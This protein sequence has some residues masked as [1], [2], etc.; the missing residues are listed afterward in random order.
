MKNKT[1]VVIIMFFLSVI[2]LYNGYCNFELPVTVKVMN[3]DDETV[4][5]ARVQAGFDTSDIV[6]KKGVQ[7]V[8]TTDREGMVSFSCYTSGHIG[9][10]V[11]KNA[12][13][14]SWVSMNFFKNP[15]EDFIRPYN[16][17]EKPIVITMRKRINPIPMHAKKV[18]T[19][20]PKSDVE[21][22]YDLMVGDWVT[23]LGKGETK[24][25]IFKT[26]GYW[27]GRYDNYSELT[28]TFSNESDG[29]I[30]FE[31]DPMY[32]SRLRSSN[33]APSEGYKNQRVWIQMR[34]PADEGKTGNDLVRRDYDKR[35]NYYL[36]V[37]SKTDK[38]GR[39][40]SA[41][42]GKIYGDIKYGGASEDGCFLIFKY[43]LNPNA[44][45]GN[46]EFD[47]EKNL[48]EDLKPLEQV[49]EP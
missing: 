8:A 18:E 26:E 11:E 44:N 25:L 2:F 30:A 23:P 48:F 27:N 29:L 13:Y 28:L 37:R 17:S 41:L 9:V 42:Y 4:K 15:D 35:S 22:G 43:Y 46:V 5:N 7:K 47:P 32:G 3:G 16:P 36:R 33:M 24:D 20:I 31:A 38:N 34:K 40:T 1:K 39:I 19:K 12:Y 14:R 6:S 49:D 10:S 45:D 21:Y